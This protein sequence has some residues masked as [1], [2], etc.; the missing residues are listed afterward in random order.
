MRVVDRGADRRLNG[1]PKQT[2]DRGDQADLR[3][4]PVL[5][6]NQ[7]D[8][9]IRPYGTAHISEQEVDRIQRVCNRPS[10]PDCRFPSH[11]HSHSV[12]ITSVTMVSGAPTRK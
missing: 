7:E 12:P 8:I 2:A 4:A 5:L 1:D 9:Q 11:S 3:L 6:R 10:A